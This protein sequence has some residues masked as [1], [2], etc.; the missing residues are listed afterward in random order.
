MDSAFCG[1]FIGDRLAHLRFGRLAGS[2]GLLRKVLELGRAQF[3]FVAV[4]H[5][6]IVHPARYA[7]AATPS[8]NLFGTSFHGTAFAV[9]L[10]LSVA[11]FRAAIRASALVRLVEHLLELFGGVRIRGERGK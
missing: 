1:V 5:G 6:R 11:K 9:A 2:S 8:F 3:R 4:V 10:V 7:A